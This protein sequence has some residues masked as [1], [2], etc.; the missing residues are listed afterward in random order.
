MRLVGAW[1]LDATQLVEP[2]VS[3]AGVHRRQ[4]TAFVPHLL[5]VRASPI[6]TESPPQVAHD[7]DVVART[8]RRL[9][10][11][12]D[13]L[14]TPFAVRHGAFRFG[15]PCGCRKHHMRQL[16]GL[17][18]KDV[19]DHQV[20]KPAQQTHRARLVGLAA[21]GI[22][23]DDVDRAQLAMVHGLEHL[24][25]VPAFVHREVG[26]APR[27]RELFVQVGDFEILETGQAGRDRP[28]VAAALDVVLPTQR[29][30]AAAVAADLARKER[31]VDQR[32]HVVYCV[33]VL[34]DAER[35]ADHP[36]LGAPVVE[37]DLLDRRG[38]HAR[39][40][41]GTLERVGLD[42]PRKF[43]VAGG[44]PRDEL[45]VGQVVVNDHSRHRVGE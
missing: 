18:E 25:E 2:R 35:P 33:V 28:H 7:V 29:V 34:C 10:R 44:G 17:G 14:H 37:R 19:L 32:D 45:L 26:A 24:A 41:F 22:L 27:P 31:Q 16:R 4:R 6:A 1:P 9:Q 15:P 20:L 12:A 36:G 5:R 13:P 21:R 23:A 30:E 11:A 40:R 3:H 38:R 42:A 43:V 39:V 8:S